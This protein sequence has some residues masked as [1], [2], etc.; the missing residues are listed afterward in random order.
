MQPTGHAPPGPALCSSWQDSCA[1]GHAPLFHRNVAPRES[2]HW[3][4]RASC[5]AQSRPQDDLRT[6]RTAL[7]PP[8]TP[9]GEARDSQAQQGRQLALGP[10][11]G[12]THTHWVAWVLPA[13]SPRLPIPCH[14]GGRPEAG[15]EVR[16]P[17][18]DRVRAGKRLPSAGPV[19][20]SAPGKAS[21]PTAASRPSPY[22]GAVGPRPDTELVQQG[23]GQRLPGWRSEGLLWV[24]PRQGPR[25]TAQPPGS[26]A[27]S[28]GG[29]VSL[30]VCR[31]PSVPT[32]TR[33]PRPGPHSAPWNPRLQQGPRSPTAGRQAG[34]AA[35]ARGTC[36]QV[37][38]WL[39]GLNQNVNGVGAA[40]GTVPKAVIVG[41]LIH[42]RPGH[43]RHSCK[44]QEIFYCL[45]QVEKTTG[46]FGAGLGGS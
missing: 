21:W 13:P 16:R 24:L 14:P 1:R 9:G 28:V 23:R 36:C 20:G 2:H 19:T 18:R 12:I 45:S 32:R 33:E 3:Q 17:L 4:A 22:T 40:C 44:A 43:E 25:P 6:P 29:W 8:P 7:S 38:P 37:G 46:G 42:K 39:S 30:P 26:G 41:P 11:V 27:P 31:V 34:R 35:H 10:G 5:L 15:R